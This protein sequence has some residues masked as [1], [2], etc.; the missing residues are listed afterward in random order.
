[1]GYEQRPRVLG[2]RPP[3]SPKEDYGPTSGN[4]TGTLY[5]LSKNAPAVEKL[6]LAEN[7][8]AR[9]PARINLKA[10]AEVLA[11]HGLDP[12]VEIIKILKSGTLDPDVQVRVLG[13]LQEYVHAK[14]KSIEVTG[15]DGGPIQME[16]LTDAT[17]AKIAMQAVDVIDVEATDVEDD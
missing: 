14:R 16:H 10:V 9:R 1:M 7:K 15:A 8:S 2:R 6:Y 12:T 11:E 3:G 17:L 13:T 5:T 4:L